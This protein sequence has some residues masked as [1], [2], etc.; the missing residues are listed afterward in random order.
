MID[1]EEQHPTVNLESEEVVDVLIIFN[2]MEINLFFG[3]ENF[4][5]NRPSH[6]DS[7][8][9]NGYP[10]MEIERYY[11]GISYPKLQDE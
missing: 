7:V 5:K 2:L 11:L 10:G 4:V 6:E 3:I 1:I 9:Q 8:N